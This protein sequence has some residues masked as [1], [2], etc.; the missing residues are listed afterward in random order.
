M[1]ITRSVIMAAALLIPAAAG[2]RDTLGIFDTW[3]AFRDTRPK[4]CFAIAEPLSDRRDAPWRP[5]ASIAWWPDKAVRGQLHL[6]LSHRRDPASPVTLGIGDQKFTLIGNASDAWA[7]DRRMDAAIIAAIRSGERLTV[8][9]RSA[10]GRRF[11]DVY[12]LRG[13]ATAMD[14]A[15]ISCAR[16]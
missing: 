6:R 14:S 2:A 3:G 4:R 15:A 16:R 7:V 8:S 11:S 5:F 12:A 10:N 13:A 9:S 1:T